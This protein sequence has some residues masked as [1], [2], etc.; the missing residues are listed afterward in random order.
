MIGQAHV[1][2][3]N[4]QPFGCASLASVP[5]ARRSMLE[6]FGIKVGLLNPQKRVSYVLSAEVDFFKQIRP[7]VLEVS[8]FA[9]TLSDE[10]GHFHK[11]PSW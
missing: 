11:P 3:I 7:G 4:F 10:E 2:A 1:S 6:R 8:R 9:H 5:Y